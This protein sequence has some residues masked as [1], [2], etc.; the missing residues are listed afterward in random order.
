MITAKEA[1]AISESVKT[2]AQHAEFFEEA[3]KQAASEGKTKIRKYHGA[4]ESAAYGNTK[5]WK[6]F[7]AYMCDLG[8]TVSLFY[9]ERQLVDMA[10]IISWD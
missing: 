8:Y 5:T 6:D 9:E 7:V 3:I 2:P 4:L 1:K 10:I